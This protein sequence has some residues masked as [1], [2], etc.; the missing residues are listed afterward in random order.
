MNQDE[1]LNALDALVS[2]EWEDMA[3]PALV[4][5]LVAGG[6]AIVPALLE[7]ITDEALRA[8]NDGDL[9]LDH[10]A[11][12]A[13]F[14]L[15]ELALPETTEP[16]FHACFES[17]DEDILEWLDSHLWR[18]GP[19]A[20]PILEQLTQKEA[21]GWYPRAMALDVM[22]QL[23]RGLPEAQ[24]SYKAFLIKVLT[25]LL[26]K[27]GDAK[28]DYITSVVSRL[29]DLRDPEARPLIDRAFEENRVD[30]DFIRKENVEAIY[31]GSMEVY[32][33]TRHESFLNY[34]RSWNL[35]SELKRREEESQRVQR[36]LAESR[37]LLA[38]IP[39]R[40]EKKP[41]RNEPCWCGSGKKYKKCH[42]DKDQ[43]R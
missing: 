17:G 7:R 10:V 40:A 25:E 37:R 9:V 29:T 19:T 41:G 5:A 18:F 15:C 13:I 42:L 32:E 2:E 34:Y 16:V 1:A 36:E 23:V 28:D 31:S 14:A 20:I 26:D 35:R 24:D 30:L 8:R 21:L 38:G 11:Y 33:S 22:A 3:P 39:A 6:E 27:G 12:M 43:G 4:E